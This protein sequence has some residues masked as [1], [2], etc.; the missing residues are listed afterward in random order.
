MLNIYR[1]TGIGVIINTVSKE[2]EHSYHQVVIF[3]IKEHRILQNLKLICPKWKDS[4]FN[5][6]AFDLT[7]NKANIN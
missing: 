6:D 7:V 3:V 4:S 2:F 1:K 5:K